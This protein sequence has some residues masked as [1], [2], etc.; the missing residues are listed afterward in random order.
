MMEVGSGGAVAVDPG[1]LRRLAAVADG[2][3]ARLEGLAGDIRRVAHEL[4]DA[5]VGLDGMYA[6]AVL[7]TAHASGAAD[8]ARAMRFTADAYE[9]VE[10]RARALMDEQD[11]ALVEMLRLRAGQLE[12]RSPGAGAEAERLLAEWR[13]EHGDEFARQLQGGPGRLLAMFGLSSPLM[14]APVPFLVEGLRRAGTGRIREGAHLRGR[15]HRPELHPGVR[16]GPG[17]SPDSLSDLGDRVPDGAEAT[18]RVER[19]TMADGRR[20]FAVYVAGT[21]GGGTTVL[22]WESNLRL[23][24]GRRSQA[25]EA[26]ELALR[27]AGAAPGD[28]LHA[29]GF[30]QGGMIV[31]WL[32][33]EG[34]YDVRTLVTLGAPAE[35]EA[36]PRTLVVTVRHDDDPVPLLVGGAAPHSLG[37]DES[38]LVQGTF[39]PMSTPR[40]LVIP[41]HR[42]PA[43]QE[44]L[45]T[46][47]G[48]G[49]P[50]VAGIRE[51][52]AVLQDASAVEVFD[53]RPE[54]SLERADRRGGG[55]F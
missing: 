4:G 34:R 22:D 16:G 5:V 3:A 18:I 51:R 10:L 23:Y 21:Q 43:Y 26:V 53:F 32:A 25:S 38:V 27:E 47:E 1:E 17:R 12:E 13:D 42:L 44:T 55:V 33:A 7:V 40:D 49:D 48:S 2:D 20:E 8:L 31:G 35:V 9:L 19:Y 52:L 54:K 39:H 24:S 15:A 36:R 28:V 30:S 41:A 37:S 46:F 6:C 50:R 14:L 45:R 29:V 11:D